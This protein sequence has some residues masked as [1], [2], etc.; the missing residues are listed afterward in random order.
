MQLFASKM[1]ELAHSQGTNTG[2]SPGQSSGANSVSKSANSEAGG[3]EKFE[4]NSGNAFDEHFKE[5]L[6]KTQSDQAQNSQA[7]ID[8]ASARLKRYRKR[9]TTC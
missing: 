7:K 8:Q 6:I 4:V 3:N 2:T 5:S 1:T 9:G